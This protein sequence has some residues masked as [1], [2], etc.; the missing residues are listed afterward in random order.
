MTRKRYIFIIEVDKAM[1]EKR[2]HVTRKKRILSVSL[3]AI[4]AMMFSSTVSA[5]TY[6]LD[7]IEDSSDPVFVSQGDIIR[8]GGVDLETNGMRVRYELSESSDEIFPGT[9]PFYKTSNHEVHGYELNGKTYDVWRVK[10]ASTGDGDFNVILIPANNDSSYYTGYFENWTLASEEPCRIRIEN[11]FEP[12]NCFANFENG[13]H[14]VYIDEGTSRQQ[15]LEYEKDFDAFYGSTIIEIDRN[16]MEF[17]PQGNHSVTV[18]FLDGRCTVNFVKGD[19]EAHAS[20]TQPANAAVQTSQ[21]TATQDVLKG[22]K[23]APKTGEI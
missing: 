18:C 17:L 8:K 7:D 10:Y 11:S 15:K 9:K 6:N 21:Q 12:E 14:R 23:P 2:T 4:L 1:N 16:I 3:I 5:K 20:G 19:N 13:S 22:K